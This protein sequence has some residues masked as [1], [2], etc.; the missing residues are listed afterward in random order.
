MVCGITRIVYVNTTVI[1][2]LGCGLLV[3]G[4]VVV[5]FLKGDALAGIGLVVTGLLV[6]RLHYTA[7]HRIEI[8]IGM[9]FMDMVTRM[10]IDI[11]MVMNMAMR[12]SIV[13]S[14]D[15]V[16]TGRSESS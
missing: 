12:E 11:E 10:A 4:N 1:M 14:T 5:I 6:L 13:M 16:T 3:I 8:I 7:D 2:G 9:W 15:T